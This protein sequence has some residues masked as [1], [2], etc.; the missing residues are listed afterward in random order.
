MTLLRILHTPDDLKRAAAASLARDYGSEL[1]DGL[2]QHSRRLTAGALTICLPRDFGFCYG[3]DRAVRYA[4]QTRARHPDKRIFMASAI[5][6]NPEVNGALRAQGVRFLTDPGE[7]PASV[8]ADDVV[9][10][11]AF[12]L[13][14]TEL[15]RFDRVGCTVVDTTCG[16]VIN[17]WKHVR[18]LAE[19]GF[20]VVVHGKIRHEETQATISRVAAV[21]GAAYLVVRNLEEAAVLAAVLRGEADAGGLRERLASAAAPH[22]DPGRH[23]ARIGLANQTTMVASESLAIG[24][25]LKQA[26]A[27]RV[28]PE[29]LDAHFRAFE[30]ICSATQ[31]RQ[32]AV[33]ELLADTPLDLML[34]LGGYD[35]SNTIAL[36]RLCEPRLP[37]YHI[38]DAS[39]LVS[40]DWI[41]HQPVGAGGPATTAGWLPDRPAI[42]VG[43]T[44]GASTPDGAVGAVIT[45]LQHLAGF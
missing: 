1:L 24:D 28:G 18:R 15:A 39:C 11:P 38:D 8:T 16:S 26:M 13:P 34:A 4:Y 9:I 33:L 23:L 36:A 29:Q 6:H 21:P 42:T 3:V 14:V 2:R 32:D 30:T 22:F 35:S 7:S 12:G 5:V 25:L 41:R 17:V 19:D 27:V 43:L 20:T 44:A 10:V 31:D 40:R 45:R 37:T